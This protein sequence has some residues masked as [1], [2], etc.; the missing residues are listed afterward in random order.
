MRKQLADNL[1]G[2]LIIVGALAMVYGISHWSGAAA[3]IVAGL[4]MS[5][6][7]MTKYTRRTP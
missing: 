7:G 1:H 3:W 4:F 5:A 2:S 6:M